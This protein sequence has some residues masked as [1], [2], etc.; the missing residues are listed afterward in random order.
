MN[1]AA[2]REDLYFLILLFFLE[3]SYIYLSQNRILMQEKTSRRTFIKTSAT[4]V[5]VAALQPNQITQWVLPPGVQAG[6]Q[7]YSV[8]D[9]LMKDVPGTLKSLSQMGYRQLEGFGLEGDK[10]LGTPL[11]E[12]GKMLKDNGC[13][14]P[15]SHAMMTSEDFD[16]TS[17]EIKDSLKKTIDAAVAQGINYVVNPW[18]SEKDRGQI[19]KMV[20]LFDAAGS[21]ARKAGGRLAYHNHNFEFETKA[22]DG[23]LLI[24]WLLHEVDP[25]NMDMEM[26][27]YW[28]YYAYNNPLDWFRLYPNRWKL[29]HVKDMAKTPQRETIEVGDG[30][31]DFNKVLKQHNQAGLQHYI[32]ELEHYKTNSMDGVKKS[33]ANFDKLRF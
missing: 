25:A 5:S 26:D 27:I 15:S 22:S 1:L 8:R 18:M 19:E 16:A 33:L 31:I 29:S 17:G 21:Y 30:T 28:V 10:L 2:S 7:I 6:L 24:E 13:T 20:K 11:K 12:I 14:M 4:A 23:R 9:A 32:I 3:A